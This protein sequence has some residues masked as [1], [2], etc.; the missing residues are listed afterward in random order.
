MQFLKLKNWEKYQHYKDRNPPWIKFYTD[1]ITSRMWVT[2]D[3][4]SRALAIAC[5]ALASKTDNRIPADPVYFQ[6]V[7]YLNSAPDFSKL[8]ET[9]FIEIVDENGTASKTL[10]ACYQLAIPEQRERGERA[11][12]RELP[13]SGAFLKFWSSW[14]KHTRKQAQGKCWSL[15]RQKD[16]DQIA[17]VVL[18]HVE[19]LKVSDDWQRGYVPAP[20]VYLNQKRWEGAEAEEVKKGVAMP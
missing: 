17:P 4:A 14:P 15:W 11:E 20:F 18:A 2:C 7:A 10:A 13:P 3:D 5:M 16:F 6:R 12:K 9:D 8:V 19:A 1:I